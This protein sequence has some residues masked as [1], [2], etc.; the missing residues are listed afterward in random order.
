[1]GVPLVYNLRNLVERKA[2]TLMTATGIALTVCVLVT[3][4]ALMNGLRSAF[5]S[6][7]NPLQ[8]LVLRK[9]GTAELSSVVQEPAFQLVKLKPGVARSATGEP[10]ASPEMVTVINLPSVESP[11]GMNVTVR[12][13]LPI[14]VSIRSLSTTAGRWFNPGIREVVVGQSIAKRYPAARLGSKLKFG[15]GEWLVVGVFSGGDSAVNSEIWCDL[16]QLAS[17]F[18]RQGAAKAGVLVRAKSPEDLDKLIDDIKNDRQLNATA[19]KE[20]E[21]YASLTSS[22]TPL[23]V[24]GTAVAV[25]MAI[26]SG[27]GAMNTMYAA[28][29]RRGREIG[30]LRSLGFSR[31]S[32]LLSFMFE[33]IVLSLLGGIL[34]CLLA[35]PING[36][37]T[38]VGSFQTFS[39]IAFQ[40]RIGITAVLVGLGFSAFIGALGGF[41]PAF[42]A[43][44]RDLLKS[45]REG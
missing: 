26:G 30:T 22:G 34:G 21:Y 18:N 43:S 14:G 38:A 6:T 5:A 41:L 35:L 44:R 8:A 7:G 12:G 10:L 45:L 24:L 39:E 25:I 33:S 27:F 19:I 40:F 31:I 20:Q 13:M 37:T 29:A 1:M 16:N 42:A 17:D 15:R 23:L 28:V 3:A 32:I 36:L 9:G 4:M 2:T 11:S